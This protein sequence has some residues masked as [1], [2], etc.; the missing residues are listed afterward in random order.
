M[1]PYKRS[2][3]FIAAILLTFIATVGAAATSSSDAAAG[4]GFGGIFM[5]AI[6]IPA[7]LLAWL[8]DYLV[9]RKSTKTTFNQP[10]QID[11]TFKRR[12][13]WIILAI[14]LVALVGIICQILA[15]NAATRP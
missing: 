11:P 14:I 3:W 4:V 15:N 9:H 10:S 5:V 8:V 7:I 12:R 2:K 13:I 1:R 6:F